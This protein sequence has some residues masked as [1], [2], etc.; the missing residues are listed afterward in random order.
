MISLS[1]VNIQVKRTNET[2]LSK[3]YS[4][5]WEGSTNQS[6]NAPYRLTNEGCIDMD[7]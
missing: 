1:L 5:F 6:M 7:N 3:K 2:H 4:L